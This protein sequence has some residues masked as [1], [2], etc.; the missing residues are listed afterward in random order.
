[1]KSTAVPAGSAMTS[2]R[3]LS[4]ARTTFWISSGRFWIVSS[5]AMIACAM[6]LNSVSDG[7][8]SMFFLAS[9]ICAV[10]SGTEASA[11]AWPERN[12]FHTL[13]GPA[14]WALT[15]SLVMPWLA[16]MPSSAK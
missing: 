1:M 4:V 10:Q 16:S 3:P 7:M 8:I 5:E 12:S 15:S 2:F 11:S 6:L 9:M 13:T 14:A